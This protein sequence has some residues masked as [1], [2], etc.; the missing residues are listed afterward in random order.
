MA[1]GI[2][3]GV[4]FWLGV[5]GVFAAVSSLVGRVL[6]LAAALLLFFFYLRFPRPRPRA[7]E[8]VFT[9]SSAFLLLTA[10]WAADFFFTPPWW[11][12]LLLLSLLMFLLFSQAFYK[13]GVRARLL[14]IMSLVATLLMVE[15][16]WATLFWPTHFLTVAATGFAGFYLVYIIGQLGLTRRL[17]RKKI[18]FQL[19]L[20][21]VFLLTIL[22]SSPWRI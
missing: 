2:I 13:M 12:V 8:D 1:T 15:V 7:L 18:Y 9:L 17:N 19:G 5:L 20:A 22:L 16:S 14:L 4:L 10:V 6:L 11:A 21:A 3:S